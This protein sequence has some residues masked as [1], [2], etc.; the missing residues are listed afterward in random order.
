[1][2]S[3][4]RHPAV[5]AGELLYA[6]PGDLSPPAKPE[7]VV[8][9]ELRPILRVCASCDVRARAKPRGHPGVNRRSDRFR[10]R[11]KRHCLGAVSLPGASWWP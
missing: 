11:R 4:E 5:L 1:M 2:R 7:C 3:C 8:G 10:R 9:R 6:S